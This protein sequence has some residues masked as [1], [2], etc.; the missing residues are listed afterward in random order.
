M[1]A[2]AAAAAAVFEQAGADADG[3]AAL[4]LEATDGAEKSESRGVERD[5]REEEEEEQGA[6]DG[7]DPG[8]PSRGGLSW[9]GPSADGEASGQLGEGS[10]WTG[11]TC[12]AGASRGQ[13]PERVE[14]ELSQGGSMLTHAGGS[15]VAGVDRSLRGRLLGRLRNPARLA[16]EVR[17]QPSYNRSR[18]LPFGRLL[19]YLLPPRFAV[20]CCQALPKS[21]MLPRGPLLQSFVAS[22]GAPQEGSDPAPSQGLSQGPGAVPSILTAPE[23]RAG[24]PRPVGALAAMGCRW[25]RSASAGPELQADAAGDSQAYGASGGMVSAW[26]GAW[27]EAVV[28]ARND[29][30]EREVCGLGHGERVAYRH[31]KR[32]GLRGRRQRPWAKHVPC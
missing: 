28:H 3:A 30:A 21:V 29:R 24:R 4:G 27:V 9:A 6:E 17:I 26:A 14:A 20:T 2:L 7:S 19:P 23:G 5:E 1:P 18:M 16:L 10:V 15:Q 11:A 13:A 12:P 31:G 32:A 22:Q 8:E 25:Q